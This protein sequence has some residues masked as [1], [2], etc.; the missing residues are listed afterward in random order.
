[1]PAPTYPPEA[2]LRAQLIELV[3][4]ADGASI[5]RFYSKITKKH[6]H[7][8]CAVQSA[9]KNNWKPR[10]TAESLRLIELLEQRV[11]LYTAAFPVGDKEPCAK[12]MLSDACHVLLRES[13]DAASIDKSVK[14]KAAA[15]ATSLACRVCEEAQSLQRE[16]GGVGLIEMQG[17]RQSPAWAP[18]VRGSG[19]VLTKDA[20]SLF[21][22][23]LGR[24]RAR[25][26][27][28]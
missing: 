26:T 19:I 2:E 25:I 16:D 13:S 6:T 17:S 20:W 4:K 1:M 14:L 8:S 23:A 11:G 12:F 9:P 18:A 28:A 24:V 7:R 5:K 22:T 15:A 21:D 3:Q 10:S 27:T